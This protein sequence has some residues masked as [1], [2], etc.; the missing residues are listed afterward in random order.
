MDS[1]GELVA[2]LR[3]VLDEAERLALTLDGES[4][5]AQD[6]DQHGMRRVTVDYSTEY[7]VACTLAARGEHI[8]RHDPAAVLADVAAKRA[9]IAWH[10]TRE[11]TGGTWDTDPKAL[12]NECE[13]LQPCR[14]VKLLASA[15][16]D[17]PGYREEWRP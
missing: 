5:S 7:V 13:D 10:C 4:W 16:A 17:R 1:I 15:Y 2:W 11:G 12:C 9:I 6:A 8:A 3:G 14:T